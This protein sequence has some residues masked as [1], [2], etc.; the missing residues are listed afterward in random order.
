MRTIA[1][2]LL[3]V[4]MIAVVWL[5]ATSGDRTA[6]LPRASGLWTID[7]SPGGV[8]V[9][10]EVR[11]PVPLARSTDAV[12]YD[13]YRPFLFQALGF[14]GGR[15]P[16]LQMPG[17]AGGGRVREGERP[18]VPELQPARYQQRR[19]QDHHLQRR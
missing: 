9:T 16:R 12:A 19:R 10:R 4:L 1:L 13:G 7:A 11:F 5:V 15:A 2:E 17:Y 14:W 3:F 18:S 8:R 6:R